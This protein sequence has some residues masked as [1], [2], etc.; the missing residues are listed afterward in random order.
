MSTA[1]APG[2]LSDLLDEYFTLDFQRFLMRHSRARAL[3]GPS[4]MGGPRGIEHWTFD[5]VRRHVDTCLRDVSMLVLELAEERG[6]APAAAV[7]LLRQRLETHFAEI[8]EQL[9]ADRNSPPANEYDVRPSAEALAEVRLYGRERLA[10]AMT[11]LSSGR[12][13]SRLTPRAGLLSQLAAR[14]GGGERLLLTAVIVLCAL[15][16]WSV[17]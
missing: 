15:W 12:L 11:A 8:H 4:L 16:L 17:L 6:F 1:V 7:P 9:L 2:D 13:E 3:A 10:K 14:A 5:Y